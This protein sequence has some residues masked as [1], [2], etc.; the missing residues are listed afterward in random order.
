[1]AGEIAKALFGPSV[2]GRIAPN[3]SA[4]V[5]FPRVRVPNWVC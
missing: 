5:H 2:L 1:V 4:R 3:V